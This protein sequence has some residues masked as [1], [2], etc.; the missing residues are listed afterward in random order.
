VFLTGGLTYEHPTETQC[1][2]VAVHYAAMY[3]FIF[4]NFVRYSLPINHRHFV[5]AIICAAPF[6]IVARKFTFYRDYGV[7][8]TIIGRIGLNLGFV[9]VLNIFYWNGWSINHQEYSNPQTTTS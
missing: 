3:I 5:F 4:A 8:T 9:I 6:L 2:Y 1:W 7:L